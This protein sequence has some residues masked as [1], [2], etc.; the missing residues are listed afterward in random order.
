MRWNA[1]Q[2][3]ETKERLLRRGDS[4][5]GIRFEWWRE[6][7]DVLCLSLKGNAISLSHTRAEAT[8]NVSEKLSVERL[9][10]FAQDVALDIYYWGIDYTPCSDESDRL[11]GSIAQPAPLDLWIATVVTSLTEREM[12]GGHL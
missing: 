11:E 10:L 4:K 9:E 1:E 2:I 12:L 3:Y 5:S 7:E 6:Y 8:Y